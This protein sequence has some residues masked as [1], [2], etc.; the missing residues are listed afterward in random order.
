MLR[1]RPP[2]AA[3]AV[4]AG[5]SALP[6]RSGWAEVAMAILTVHHWDDWERGLAE[7]C[8]VAPR[9]LVFGIDFEV[10]AQFWLLQEYLPSVLEHT[11]ACGPPADVIAEAIGADHVDRAADV[12]RPPGRRTR[13]P[14][15]STGGISRPRSS[16]PTTRGRAL[17][18][19]ADHVSRYR[20][21]RGR[22]GER[23]LA[24]A[25][26]TTCWSASRSTWGTGSSSRSKPVVSLRPMRSSDLALVERWLGEPH[27]ARWYLAGS[28]LER[29]LGDM[30]SS[31]RGDQAVHV[32]V[33]LD[34]RR[35]GR[36]VPVV[37]VL[38]GP[39]VGR[40]DRCRDRAT[41][42]WTTPSASPQP[43][44][45]GVGTE[46]VAALVRVGADGAAG[47]RGRGRPRGGQRGVASGAGEERVRALG[48]EDARQRTDRR[49][50]GDLPPSGELR[51][52]MN[53]LGLPSLVR[54]REDVALSCPRAGLAATSTT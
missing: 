6:L 7:L 47:V 18:D 40:R 48:G 20:T 49:P 28:S 50:D 13:C 9:R 25:S 46:L 31:V 1:Q 22:P 16:G 27:V 43:V 26:C 21:P 11:L 17:A 8:R 24:R 54:F 36:L 32:L 23:R 14:L 29:E 4:R 38:R 45:R 41:S 51:R 5:A 12:R 42:A 3:P 30:R 35:A 39:G 44:G 53:G 52:P 19:P 10:H 2:G 37:S 34:G 15:E 33:V